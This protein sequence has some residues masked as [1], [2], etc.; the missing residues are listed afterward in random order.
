MTNRYLEIKD[1]L[2]YETALVFFLKK[3]GEKRVMLA[4]RNLRTGKLCQCGSG[5][6]GKRE[7]SNNIN[8]GNILVIDLM[9]GALRTFNVD[10]I[11]SIEYCDVIESEKELAVAYSRYKDMCN[12]SCSIEDTLV[13]NEGIGGVVI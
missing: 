6:G 11:I 1:R 2:F 3:T 4:T 12:Y 13:G 7:D 5:L 9:K 10:R 8:N